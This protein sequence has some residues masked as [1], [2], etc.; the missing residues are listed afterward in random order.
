MNK[1]NVVKVSKKYKKLYDLL[2]GYMEKGILKE[3]FTR[4]QFREK[5]YDDVTADYDIHKTNLLDHFFKV[6][7]RCEIIYV[8]DERNHVFQINQ[9]LNE[10]EILEDLVKRG[11]EVKKSEWDDAPNKRK[12]AHYSIINSKLERGKGF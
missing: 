6:L 4:D 1:N 2:S 9:K 10:N 8:K 3:T 5:L 12:M 7:K 11:Y